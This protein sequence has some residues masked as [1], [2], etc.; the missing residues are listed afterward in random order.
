M[1]D[2]ASVVG[3]EIDFL[4]VENAEGNS[5]KSGD[6]I[7]ARLLLADGGRRVIV[8]DGG[9]RG[10]GD[11]L[12]D[13]IH[14]LYHTDVVDIVI[15]TH[16]DADHINGLERVLTNMNVR[17]LLIHNPHNHVA[18]VADFENIEAVD[19]LLDVASQRKE[20]LSACG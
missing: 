17:E 15:S 8:V 16:P 13:H 19:K 2:A 3:Y 6:A 20:N 10:I 18:N 1:M 14:Q 4:P 7:A 5:R 12:V 9:F 11:N